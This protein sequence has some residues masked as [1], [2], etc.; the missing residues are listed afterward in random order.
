MIG[1]SIMPSARSSVLAT[2]AVAGLVAGGVGLA[3]S[4][5]E[6][7][8]GRSAAT[9]TGAAPVVSPDPVRAGDVL[10]V[11][12]SGC[13]AGDDTEVYGQLLDD[14]GADNADGD[15]TD[16]A[17]DG[18]WTMT[19]DVPD[20]AVPGS[21]VVAS[22]CDSYVDGFDYP[23]AAVRVV[24]AKLGTSLSVAAPDQIVSGGKA[25]V[26]GRLTTSDGGVRGVRVKLQARAAGQSGFHTVAT[27]ETSSTGA[28]HITERP[29]V[30]TAYRWVYAGS[31]R[32]DDVTSSAEPVAVA[33]HVSLTLTDKKIKK[34][35]DLAAYGTV[36]PLKSGLNVTLQRL[37]HNAWLPLDKAS[38]KKQLLPTGK[39]AYGYEFDLT[40]SK[41][42]SY[43]LRVVS[44]GSSAN[45]G[46]TSATKSVT[47]V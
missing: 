39:K 23:D 28:V 42:G 2:L 9:A 35:R 47:I 1:K 43:Q 38:V 24:S 41:R 20:D 8:G 11:T 40:G 32:Y 5:A 46:G 36:D 13:T 10:T 18:T 4:S 6:A 15:T 45:A 12:G 3:V 30:R 44:A 34:N 14:G 37:V 16:I 19:F 27:V 21:Y 17:E 26:T 7:S 25:A 31:T 22:T 29:S 33:F